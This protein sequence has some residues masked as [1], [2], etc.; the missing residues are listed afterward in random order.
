LF[1]TACHYERVPGAMPKQD[2]VD[3]TEQIDPEWRNGFYV[4]TGI[5][6]TL[7]GRIGTTVRAMP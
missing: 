6:A 5:T 4:V 3:A 2:R 1:F 7:R